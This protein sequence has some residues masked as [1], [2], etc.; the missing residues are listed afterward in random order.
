[1]RF[2][3]LLK[4]IFKK[5]K[6]LNHRIRLKYY[7]IKKEEVLI[8][9]NKTQFVGIDYLDKYFISISSNG[10]IGSIVSGVNKKRETFI[11]FIFKLSA[12][13]IQTIDSTGE[14]AFTYSVKTLFGKEETFLEV[15]VRNLCEKLRKQFSITKP[16]LVSIGVTKEQINIQTLK[17]YENSIL[18]SIQV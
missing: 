18:K 1:M 11:I 15:F 16:L 5:K 14:Q 4:F 9:S 13:S 6:P 17:Q 12:S 2:F 7:I 8:D 3:F 10:K